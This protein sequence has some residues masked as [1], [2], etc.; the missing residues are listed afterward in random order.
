MA[1]RVQGPDHIGDRELL[2]QDRRP[3]TSSATP[4]T[5]ACRMP[6][7]TGCRSYSVDSAGIRKAV[8]LKSELYSPSRSHLTQPPQI[9]AVE[10]IVRC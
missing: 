4:V 3:R 5:F 8:S 9:I 2:F 7:A 1:P 6:A 10:R